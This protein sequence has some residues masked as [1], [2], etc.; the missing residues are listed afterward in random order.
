MDNRISTYQYKRSAH[1]P[2][3]VLQEALEIKRRPVP[4]VAPVVEAVLVAEAAVEEPV[5]KKAGQT[6]K[7]C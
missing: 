3:R 2:H 1:S 5:K 7:I 4:A 6:K